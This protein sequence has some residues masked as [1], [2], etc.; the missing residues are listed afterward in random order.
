MTPAVPF[1]LTPHA[2]VALVFIRSYMREH[3]GVSPSYN[4]IAKF[5]GIVSR[6]GVHRIVNELEKRGRVRRIPQHERSLIPVEIFAIPE[7]ALGR[8]VDYAETESI[9]LEVAVQHMIERGLGEPRKK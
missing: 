6:S 9:S 5:L 1:G 3:N 4:E 7:S 8:L 2:R